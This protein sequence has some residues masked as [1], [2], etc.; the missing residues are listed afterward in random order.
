MP[1]LAKGAW[2]DLFSAVQFGRSSNNI[3]LQIQQAIYQGR[4]EIGQRLPNER[5]LGELFGVSRSTLR[6]AIRM[7]E[8]EGIVEVRRGTTGG[9]FVSQPKVDRIGFAL[10]ALIRLQQATPEHFVEFRLTFEPES[11]RIAAVKATTEKRTRLMELAELCGA[12][13]DGSVT[14]WDAYIAADIDFHNEVANATGNPI[15]YAVMLGVHEAFR[16]SS[17]S[18]S[19]HDSLAWRTERTEEVLGIARAIRDRKPSV[20]HRRMKEHL[21]ANASVVVETLNHP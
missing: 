14:P 10:A 13:T 6:E 17:L 19:R 16:Q 4:L 12:G 7:L 15:R 11:A 3:A 5:D 21:L 9:S 18:I 8:A 20:A 1:D 2:E